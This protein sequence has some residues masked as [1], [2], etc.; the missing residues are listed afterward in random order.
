MRMSSRPARARMRCQGC[1]RSVRWVPGFLP[2]IDHPGIVRVARQSRQQPH[3]VRR[4]RDRPPAGLAVG[5]PQ[6]AGI[7]VDMFPA[8]FLAFQEPAAGQHQELDRRRRAGLRAVR[9]YLVEDPP[10]PI[11]L[12]GLAVGKETD[13][14]QA[15]CLQAVAGRPFTAADSSPAI[16]SLPTK[17]A[18][19]AIVAR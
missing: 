17:T 16:V 12:D 1:C 14:R 18:P 4:Q 15:T 3:G 2:A 8:Q 6:L 13:A 9:R 5:K 7:E 19:V 11:E 10:E